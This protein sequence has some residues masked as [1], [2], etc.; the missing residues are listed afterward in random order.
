VHGRVSDESAG[1]KVAQLGSPFVDFNYVDDHGKSRSFHAEMGDFAVPVFTR[2][3]NNMH[4]PA[5]DWLQKVVDDNRSV[6]NVR[7]VGVDVHWSSGGCKANDQCHLIAARSSLGILCDATGAVHRAHGATNED[8]V[9]VIGPE[10]HIL[11]SGPMKDAAQIAR[12]L[13]LRIERLLRV[14]KGTGTSPEDHLAIA[15]QARLGASP[16]FQLIVRPVARSVWYAFH[17]ARASRRCG[18]LLG[19]P[20]SGPMLTRLTPS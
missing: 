3:D 17:F 6:N 16:L 5:V 12:E 13:K 2:S 19:A 8:W 18:P 1:S 7:L 10:Q 20:G 11:F 4:R 9:C 15:E 14:E